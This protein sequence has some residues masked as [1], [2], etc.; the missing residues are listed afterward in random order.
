MARL[1]PSRFACA[2]TRVPVGAY[3]SM[4]P[5]MNHFAFAKG[6]TVLQISTIG[7]WGITYINPADD[8]RKR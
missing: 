2:L 8:P 7:P 1:F 4:P 5:G 6:P 3:T